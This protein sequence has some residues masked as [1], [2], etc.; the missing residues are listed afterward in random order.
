MAVGHDAH[1]LGA[2][3]MLQPYTT[4][5]TYSER[6]EAAHEAGRKARRIGRPFSDCPHQEGTPA[7]REW[8][9]GWHDETPSRGE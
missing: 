4:E 8:R 9:D 2:G 3:V 7:S 6:M 1:A 5:P